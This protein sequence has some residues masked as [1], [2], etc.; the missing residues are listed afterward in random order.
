ML[1]DKLLPV[2]ISGLPGDRDIGVYGENLPPVTPVRHNTQEEVATSDSSLASSLLEEIES[3]EHHSPVLT[4]AHRLQHA[5]NQ[6][7]SLAAIDASESR[8][9][10]IQNT[11]HQERMGVNQSMASEMRQMK[12]I[13]IKIPEELHIMNKTFKT[14]VNTLLLVNNLLPDSTGNEGQFSGNNEGSFYAGILSP[15]TEVLNVSSDDI[16]EVRSFNLESPTRV[17]PMQTS[18]IDDNLQEAPK[19][20]KKRKLSNTETELTSLGC[21]TLSNNGQQYTQPQGTPV[22]KL[23]QSLQAYI[24]AQGTPVFKLPQ[25][26]QAYIQAQGTHVYNQARNLTLSSQAQTAPVCTL[27]Q[28]APV[29]TQAQNALVCTQA[30]SGF[31]LTILQLFQCLPRPK[32]SAPVFTQTQ[33]APVFTQ[34]QS[35]PVCTQAQSGLFFNHPPIVP[36]STQAQGTHVY[37]QPQILTVSTHGQS[38]AAI[39]HTQSAAVITSKKTT[40]RGVKPQTNESEPSNRQVTRSQIKK[41]K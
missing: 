13:I 14:L 2:V 4:E 5:R 17:E 9:I 23:P 36:V 10:L 25:S 1:R 39:V 35:A 7:D 21:K 18:S 22:F 15:E 32:V 19:R 16:S 33:S 38:G 20:S 26:L 11:H 6:Q 40:K 12:Q 34:A 8:M 41:T 30:Q 27:A 28:S 29:F 37:N 31:S 24:Q 3:P